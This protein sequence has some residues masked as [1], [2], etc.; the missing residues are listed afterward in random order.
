MPPEPDPDVDVDVA[1]PTPGQVRSA[2]RGTYIAFAGSGFAFASWASRIPQ[3]RDHLHL[4]P[5]ALG[6][7]LFAIAAGSIVALPLAGAVV[8]RLGSRRAVASMTVPLSVGLAVVAVGYL[9]GTP[10]VVVGLFLLGFANGTW[11]VAMNVQ[12]AIVERHLGRSIMARFHAGWSL[13]TVTGA[14]VGAAMVALHV[15]VTAHLLVVAVGTC[16]AVTRGTGCSCTTPRVSRRRSRP[17]ARAARWRR[18]ANRAP[19]SSAC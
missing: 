18:G 11:D 13:G 3:V 10:V 7:V 6:L 4:S 14:L 1:A 9:I 12:G 8:H 5:S 19:C 17:A 15:P 2:V 16:L